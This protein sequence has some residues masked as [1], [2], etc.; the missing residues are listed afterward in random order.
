MYKRKTLLSTLYQNKIEF[1][2]YSVSKIVWQR[3]TFDGKIGK[4]NWLMWRGAYK[5]VEINE[6]K[7]WKPWDSTQLRIFERGFRFRRL[8]FGFTFPMWIEGF[9]GWLGCGDEEIDE[10]SWWKLKRVESLKISQFGDL[11]FLES[12]KRK[13]SW[14]YFFSKRFHLFWSSKSRV[15]LP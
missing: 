9:S 10:K 13:V 5:S 6:N 1:I 7:W 8:G 14:R 15:M 4:L 3:Q 11:G 2:W 12:W